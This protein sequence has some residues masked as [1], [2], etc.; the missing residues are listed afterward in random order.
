MP[1]TLVRL[2]KENRTPVATATA[3]VAEMDVAPPVW[4]R[5]GGGAGKWLV[6]NRRRAAIIAGGSLTLLTLTVATWSYVAGLRAAQTR[7]VSLEEALTA[8]DDNKLDVAR[9]VAARIQNDEQ[10]TPEQAGQAAYV[11]GIAQ[12]READGLWEEDK[13][14]SYLIA[15]RYLEEAHDTGFPEGRE[16]V[17]LL[18]YG[19]SLCL[20]KQ[21]ALSRPVLLRAMTANPNDTSLI[22]SLLT[23]AYLGDTVPNLKKALAHNLLYQ[24]DPLLE[25]DPRSEAVLQQC[26]ILLRLDDIETCRQVIATFPEDSNV[27][28]KALV[29]QAR[30]AMH[31]AR[32]LSEQDEPGARAKLQQAIELL[33]QATGRDR[34]GTSATR[35]SIYLRGLCYAEL[36]QTAEAIDLLERAHKLYYD[37]PEGL[38]A[39]L[40]TADLLREQ[41]DHE[42]AVTVYRRAFEAA[43]TPT[44]YSN[45]W[46][47]LTEFHSRMLRAHQDYLEAKNFEAALTLAA[48]FTPI[49]PRVRSVELQAET[50]QAWADT[51]IAQTEGLTHAEAAPLREQARMHWRQS[52]SMFADLAKLRIA[53]R[54]YPNDLWRAAVNLFEGHD[55][56]QAQRLLTAYLRNET[57]LHQPHAL[58]LLGKANLTLGRVEES[59][60]NLLDCMEAYPRDASTYEARI[61]AAK[62]YQENDQPQ[63]A[64]EIL[65]A[66]LEGDV[67][68]PASR[69]WRDSLFDLGF[70]NHKLG[71]YEEAIERLSEASQRY[72]DIPRAI[73]AEYII[74][75][76]YRQ[77]ADAPKKRLQQASFES[78]RRSYR[79]QKRVLLDNAVKYYE[80]V[81][82]AL[83][84]KEEKVPLTDLEAAMLR[85]C[86]FSMGAVLFDLGRYEEAIQ[87]YSNASTRY[88]NEPLVLEAYVQIA[89]A[90]RRL[91]HVIPARGALAQ[92]KVVWQ[93]FPQDTDFTTTTNYS[94]EQWQQLLDNLQ[95][96]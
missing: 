12:L 67:L 31:D 18:A 58:T 85:N 89:D 38:S 54:A 8:L 44:E 84:H 47:P 13:S 66:N 96:W 88:Q 70:L 24:E 92:A 48:G 69:E 23:E 90:H 46:I 32:L 72:R 7:R 59:L 74:A 21:F 30:L 57:R 53:T 27:Q 79:K 51:L 29:V 60:R 28:G 82:A 11:L 20:G 71:N 83:N 93:R 77:S 37:A 73:E 76:S 50:H 65:L 45:P 14:R 63:R 1:L 43:G 52:G 61:W 36:G 87:A 78:V 55:Y 33:E 64:K 62:A 41:G 75:E 22:H 91:G 6:E 15:A 16:A 40:L 9:G 42:E 26:D 17:G 39:D 2:L 49:M 3:D 80:R 81:Q 25:S 4:R 5:W 86:Y 94:R 34:V 10:S 35:Q 56:R 19:R 95:T 68:T